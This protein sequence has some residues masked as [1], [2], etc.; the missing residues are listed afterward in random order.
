[1]PL[2]QP[3]LCRTWSETPKTGILTTR[4]ICKTKDQMESSRPKYVQGIPAIR[5]TIYGKQSTSLNTITG[6]FCTCKS[7]ARVVGCCAHL[8]CGIWTLNGIN[9]QQKHLKYMTST[10][11]L[12]QILQLKFGILAAPVAEWVR[13]LY[14]SALNHSIISP[15]CL[16]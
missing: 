8:S 4:L 11:I 10:W 13:S 5:H 12:S 2:V 6:W 9:Q 16:V 1:M 14:F 15:L 7:G 3:G